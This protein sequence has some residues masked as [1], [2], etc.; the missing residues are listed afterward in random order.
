[1]RIVII[2][3]SDST[4][5]AAV[6][7][8]RLME[9]MR[10]S[11]IDARMLV[12]EK[13]SDSPFVTLAASAWAIKSRFLL[14]R[15]KIFL[16]NGFNRSTLFKIDTGTEGLPLWKNPIVKNADAL[17]INWVNQ[18]ML[19]LKGFEKILK[20][21]KPTIVTMHDMWWMTGICHHAGEC[22]HFEK[23]CGN[24]PLLGKHGR[25][26]DFSFKVHREKQ[27][28]YNRKGIDRRLAFVAVSSW[29]KTRG[30]ESSLLKNQH[31]EVIPNVFSPV[32]MREL[33]ENVIENK[34]GKIR[35]LFGAARLDD[36][37][38][39]LDTL[40]EATLIL[41]ESYPE[42]ASQMELRFFGIAKNPDS[43]KGFG[44]P[45]FSLGIMRREE[46]LAKVYS[47]ADILVSASDYETLPG[48][49]VEA[50]AYG[51]VPVSFNRGGQGDIITDDSKGI[52]VDYDSDL[53]TRAENLARGI[54]EAFDIVGNHER[55][56]NMK[57]EMEENVRFKFSPS[58]VAER[59][60]RLIEWLRTL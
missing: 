27:K 53:Q 10:N 7:S 13:L 40:R 34:K 48:T 28:I 39:G 49:L 38:K 52:L 46:E 36:P 15:L 33:P 57:T 30:E 25:P 55:L 2:N 41:K 22:S 56:E 17:L 14:E 11:G 44:L 19:S 58:L 45:V 1:M 26:A 16:A 35:I 9:A 42:K 43:L 51:C 20:L 8:R 60:L 5:G 21:G 29:L 12:C 37:I 47:G 23:D 24:C 18:G 32:S 54:A 59:Y 6:V 3:K 50:Q 4:G 31:L